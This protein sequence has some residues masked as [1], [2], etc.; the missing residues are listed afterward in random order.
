MVLGFLVAVAAVAVSYAMY[1]H[2]GLAAIKAE[3]NTLE[4]EAKDEFDKV[5]AEVVARLKG[6]L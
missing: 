1:K 5:K 4:Q 3:L 2:Y 6:L